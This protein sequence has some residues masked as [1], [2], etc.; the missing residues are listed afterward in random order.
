MSLGHILHCFLRTPRWHLCV[1]GRYAGGRPSLH[2]QL[3]KNKRC[4]PDIFR[5]PNITLFNTRK[6]QLNGSCASW[7]HKHSC[8]FCYRTKCNVILHFSCKLTVCR[9]CLFVGLCSCTLRGF[10]D[11]SCAAGIFG[12]CFRLHVLIRFSGSVTFCLILEF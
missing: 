9:Q 3:L 12:G 2:V 7:R 6:T 11:G 8:C 10:W 5:A 4:S 1:S